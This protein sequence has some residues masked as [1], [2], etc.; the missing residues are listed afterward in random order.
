MEHRVLLEPVRLT[1][2]AIEE[3]VLLVRPEEVSGQRRVPETSLRYEFLTSYY[4][5]R[6]VLRGN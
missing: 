5:G 2:I 6:I 4:K 1:E 3:F